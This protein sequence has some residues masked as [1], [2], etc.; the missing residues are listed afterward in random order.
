[1][2]TQKN[3]VSKTNQ[4]TNQPSNQPTKDK[5]QK[6]RSYLKTKSVQGYL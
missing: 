6:E 1:M 2:A 5:N 3:P 4:S